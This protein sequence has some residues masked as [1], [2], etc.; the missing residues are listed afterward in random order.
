M[1]SKVRLWT[2]EISHL[3]KNSYLAM[4]IIPDVKVDRISGNSCD[5]QF[6][7]Y[8]HLLSIDYLIVVSYSYM[9]MMHAKASKIVLYYNLK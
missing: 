6:H 3:E 2:L 4:P 5:V 7:G 8:S 9:H 1:C